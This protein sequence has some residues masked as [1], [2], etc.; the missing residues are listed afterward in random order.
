[1]QFKILSKEGFDKASDH[2]PP[3]LVCSSA[4]FSNFEVWKGAK[5]FASPQRVMILGHLHLFSPLWRMRG[6]LERGCWQVHA[7]QPMCFPILREAGGTPA[8]PLG[9]AQSPS[10]RANSLPVSANGLPD[11]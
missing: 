9:E 6:H 10:L 8:R 5:L 2:I 7:T 1:M 4:Q 11:N 3:G